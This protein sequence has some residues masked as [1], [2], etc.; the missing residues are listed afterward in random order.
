MLLVLAF[1]ITWVVFSLLIFPNLNTLYETFFSS[2]SFSLEPIQKLLKSERALWSILNS[3]ILAVILVITVNAVGIFLVLATQYFDIKGARFI[4]YS[5]YSTLIYGGVALNLGYK[6]VYGENGPITQLLLQINPNMNE[7]W[8]TGLFAVV[9]VMSFACT[10]NHMLFLTS[11]IRNVDYH[12]IEAAK[13]L[14]ASQ[15]TIIKNVVIPT[16]KPTLFAVTILTFLTG[17]SATSAPLV[18]GGKDFETIT[19][20]ILT[21]ARS[22]SSKDL[23]TVLALVLGILTIIVLFFMLRSEEKGNYISISKTKMSFKKQ[24]IENRLGNVI[25]HLITY[26]L[27]V[28]YTLPVLAVIV[29]S[30]TDSLAISTG[31]IALDSFTLA[32]YSLTFSSID[33]LEPYVVSLSYGLVASVLVIIFCLLCA[34]L[35]KKYKNILTKSLDYLLMIPWFLPSVLI[36]VGLTVTFNVN[37]PVVFNKV[38]TGTVWVLLIGYF[39][40]KIPFTLRITKS[41]FYG[42]NNEIEE[43]A[44]NLG[45]NAF[46]TFIR[47]VLPVIIPSILGVFALNFIDILPDY[48]LTVFLYHPLY[49]PLGVTIM[50]ATGNSVAADTKALSLVY[51]VILMIINTVILALVYGNGF[52]NKRTG[53]NG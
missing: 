10:S 23:A 50:N 41:A 43:A 42:I 36:A 29:Y 15:F 4:K 39:V 20:M 1:V 31:V 25:V 5:F 53:V 38:L 16:L 13:N 32:N 51:T 26:V 35:M 33:A 17:L 11:A 19:P 40:V 7:S 48:D 44:K 49:E 21:F 30:F 46:Y 52:N 24:K 8:F 47:V 12:T 2:G 18:F 9:F 14:G 27:F 45:A 22:S 3:I 34:Y 6:L 37:Q 28:I